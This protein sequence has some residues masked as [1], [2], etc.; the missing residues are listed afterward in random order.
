AGEIFKDLAPSG[1]IRRTASVAF[2]DNHHI[3]KLSGDVF[4]NLVFLVGTRDSLIQP[5]INFIRRIDFAILDFRHDGAERLEVI[6]EGLVDQDI[7]IYKEQD[8]LNQP[9]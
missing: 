3:K 4:E 6:N 9:R 8:A 1:I 5:Q 2:I 7:S